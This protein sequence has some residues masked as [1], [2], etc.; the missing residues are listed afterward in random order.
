MAD[1]K[2]APFARKGILIV[3]VLSVFFPRS[4]LGVSYLHLNGQPSLQVEIPD[5]VDLTADCAQPGNRLKGEIFLDANENGVVDGAEPLVQFVYLTDGV[6]TLEN[7]KGDEIPGDDDALADGH[8]LRHMELT[9]EDTRITTRPFDLILRITDQDGSWAQAF[10]EVV[11][12]PVARP[13]IGGTVTDA[14]TGAPL[15]SILVAAQE[16]VTEE[17]KA[18]ITDPQGSYVLKLAAGTWSLSARELYGG[19]AP[20]DTQVAILSADDSTGIDLTLSTYP[21][22]ITGVV[23][24][25]GG[26]PA[27]GIRVLATAM[28]STRYVGHSRADGS[29][30]LGV[31]PGTYRI[32]PVFL[33]EGLAFSP[34]GYQVTVDSGATVA[35]KDFTLRT[36][37]NSIA[38]VVSYQAGGGAA[39]VTV[40]AYSPGLVHTTTTDLDGS[41]F[42]AVLPRE[43]M[44]LA[45]REDYQVVY[46]PT[47]IYYFVDT[48]EDPNVTGL[49]FSIAPSVGQPLSISGTVTYQA[50]G[51]HASG[52]LVIISDDAEDSPLGWAFAETNSVGHYQFSDIPPGTWLVGVYQPGYSSSPLLREQVLS[53][54]DPP[55]IQQDFQLEAATGISRQWDVRL[56]RKCHLS[57]NH[58]NP[59]NATTLMAYTL[60]DAEPNLVTMK[61]FNILGQEIRTL[62]KDHQTA[63]RYLVRWDGRDQ[64]GLPV[65]SGI[66]FCELRAGSQRQARKLLL[67]R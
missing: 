22:Y 3:A 12:P 4:G 63:G 49:D 36:S 17:I 35:N 41:Y 48:F 47:Q 6:P 57:Q 34:N 40:T 7:Q 32:Y 31:T 58:P 14:S 18:T 56:P 52:V 54:G 15:D 16:A 5:T 29:Y 60:S 66:Y 64:N 51:G 9:E 10:L 13:C 25:M 23:N 2:K 21:G 30:T 65:A 33:P 59:F 24:N 19:Y 53:R 20:S 55:A 39:G 62:V 50:T 44:V 28:P 11:P 61:V 45:E 38:G 27:P 37:G 1:R 67:L 26:G 8:I 42:L 43:Y 46:P